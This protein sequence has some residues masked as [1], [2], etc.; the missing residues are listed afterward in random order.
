MLNNVIQ[1]YTMLHQVLGC[2]LILRNVLKHLNDVL[3]LVCVKN[4]LVVL[5]CESAGNKILVCQDIIVQRPSKFQVSALSVVFCHLSSYT[6]VRYPTCQENKMYLF[7][8]HVFIL[9]LPG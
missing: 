1:C 6:A 9:V 7:H 2:G 5:W 8:H 4:V 3:K